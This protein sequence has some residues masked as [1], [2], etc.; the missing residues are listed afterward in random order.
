MTEVTFTHV[1]NLIRQESKALRDEMRQSFEMLRNND[2]AHI[3]QRLGGMEGSIAG[4]N[5][6]LDGIEG[7]LGAI[8]D[9]F[10]I[11]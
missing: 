4:I 5:G 6:R 3:E 2:L 10:G 1:E 7:D 9:H 11:E 8:K